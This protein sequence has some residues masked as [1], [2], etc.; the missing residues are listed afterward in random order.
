MNPYA[1]LAALLSRLPESLWLLVCRIG[2]GAIFF[3]SGR[4]KV[5]GLLTLKDS[6]Y[7]CW[8]WACSPGPA[9]WACWA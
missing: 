3:L 9:R 6:T 4:T 8:P 1:A 2:I 7:T 5:D